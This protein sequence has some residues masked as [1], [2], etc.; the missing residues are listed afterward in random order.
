[1]MTENRISE[2]SVKNNGDYSEL[3]QALL[4]GNATP[5]DELT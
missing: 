3:F 5:L 1:M 4:N 2:L